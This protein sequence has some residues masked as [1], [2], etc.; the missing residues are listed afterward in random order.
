MATTSKNMMREQRKRNNLFI[1]PPVVHVS[2]FLWS[3][4]IE[5]P[6]AAAAQHG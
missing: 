6:A 5:C 2:P 4:K 3:D 1:F